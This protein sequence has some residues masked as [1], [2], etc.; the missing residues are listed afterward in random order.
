VIS[1][2][3][4]GS[5][6]FVMR[7]VHYHRITGSAQPC[8]RSLA[9]LCRSIFRTL[10]ELCSNLIYRRFTHYDAEATPDF[11]EAVAWYHKAAEAGNT[12]AMNNLGGAYYHGIGVQKGDKQAVAWYRKAAEAGNAD[13]MNNLGSAY[14]H[15]IGVQRDDNLAVAWYRKAAQLGNLDAKTNLQQLGVN[16]Q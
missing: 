13:A 1:K 14:L 6:D 12:D 16:P 5:R 8:R 15:G 7:K 11:N 3:R 9:D 10:R 4:N 2:N